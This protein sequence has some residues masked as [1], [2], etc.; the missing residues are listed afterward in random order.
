VFTKFRDGEVAVAGGWPTERPST[1]QAYAILQ[2]LGMAS[3]ATV[4]TDKLD[5]NLH[6]SLRNVPLVDVCTVADLNAR[7]VLLRRHLVVTPAA[8][9][10][11]K[12]TLGRKSS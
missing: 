8:L 6:L 4:V 2:K 7:Q 3:S 10:V 1:K 5:R 9:D 11:I 12:Q